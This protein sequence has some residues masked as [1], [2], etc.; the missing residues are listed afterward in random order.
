MQLCVCVLPNP[1]VMTRCAAWVWKAGGRAD[2]WSSRHEQAG[3]EKV[4]QGQG[5]WQGYGQESGGY[6]ELLGFR[7]KPQCAF[8]ALLKASHASWAAKSN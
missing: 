7:L 6:R 3:R 1:F 2:R 5:S 4:V 8:S